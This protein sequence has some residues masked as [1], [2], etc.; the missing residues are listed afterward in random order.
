MHSVYKFLLE[1]EFDEKKKGKRKREGRGRRQR[2]VFK[3]RYI[4][5]PAPCLSTTV[6][7]VT[8]ATLA[9]A[10]ASDTLGVGQLCAHTRP[11]NK[12]L[13]FLTRLQTSVL[14]AS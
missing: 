3:S 8:R 9:Y 4:S 12:A 10:G 6:R 5:F 2:S 11:K 7:V 13:T 14:S 1:I